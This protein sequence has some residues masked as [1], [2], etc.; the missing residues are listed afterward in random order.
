SAEDATEILR[1]ARRYA[2][3]LGVSFHVG[4][5]AM[6]PTAWWTAMADVSRIIIAASV[7]VDIVDVGGGFPSIY[8]DNPPPSL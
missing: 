3:E 7:T 4:S 6:K 2:D 8:A 5:Q 1:E